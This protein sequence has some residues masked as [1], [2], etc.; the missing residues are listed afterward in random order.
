MSQA[1]TRTIAVG[2]KTVEIPLPVHRKV[3][4]LIDKGNKID[5]VVAVRKLARVELKAAKEAI[6]NPDNFD[7]G[8]ESVD[9]SPFDF[10][11][12]LRKLITGEVKPRQWMALHPQVSGG[13]GAAM[14]ALSLMIATTMAW[15]GPSYTRSAGVWYYDLAEQALFEH[16]YAGSPIEGMDG[17]ADGALRA[18]VFACESCGSDRFIG[19]VESF[20]DA[21]M[22]IQRKLRDGEQIEDEAT[23]L[24][25]LTE[26]HRIRAVDSEDWVGFDSKEGKKLRRS[27]SDRCDGAR[28]RACLP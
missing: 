10:A 20:D 21:A 22:E 9:R 7:T 26:G 17:Q 13:V 23:M 19:F 18:Y 15:S 25:A 28:P 24:K 5:A 11:D 1:L 8:G 3:Q 4:V 6:E 27:V 12:E 16:P 2:G 14:L